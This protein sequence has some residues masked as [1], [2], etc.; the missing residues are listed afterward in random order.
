M[1]HQV[2]QASL[3][4]SS[5]NEADASALSTVSS[6][7]D[8]AE[9]KKPDIV[10]KSSDLSMVMNATHLARAAAIELIQSADGDIKRALRSFVSSESA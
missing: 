9:E 10:I 3:F 1:T 5:Q 4:R 8:E 2:D 7:H 6:I